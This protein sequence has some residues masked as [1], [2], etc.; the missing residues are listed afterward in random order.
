MELSQPLSDTEIDE[1]GDFL[2]S[3]STP[4][5]CMDISMLDGFLTAIVIGPNMIMPSQWLPQVWGETPQRPMRWDSPQQMKRIMSLVMRHMNDIIWQLTEDP[6]HYEPLLFEHDQE[7]GP[8][9]IIDEWCTGFIRGATLDSEAWQSLFESDECQGF[10]LPII[11]Y[12]TESGWRELEEKPELEER[13][14][15]FAASLADCVLAIQD[16]WLPIRKAK[17]TIRHA[18]PAPGR[19][20]PCSCGSGRKFKKCCGSASKLN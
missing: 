12:G 2:M 1:L 17:S 14:D 19:N 4:D 5:E 3:D 8:V 9:L 6:E 20:D 10:L 7:E 16:Y 13:H 18:E 11:L 15:E